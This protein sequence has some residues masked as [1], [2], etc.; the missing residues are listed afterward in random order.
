MDKRRR[1]CT[2]FLVGKKASVDGSTIIARIED[3][4]SKPNPQRFVVVTPDKQPKKFVSAEYQISISLPD[5]PLRYTSTPDADDTHGVWAGAGINSENVAMTSSETIT[6]NSKILALDPLVNGI[7]EADI[8][9]LVLPYIYSAKE[10]VERL[11]SLLETYGTYES[12]GIS[13]SDKEEVWYMETIGGHHWVAQRIPDEAYVIAPNRFNIT[14][15][16]FQSNNTLASNGL[17]Q[18]INT[19]HLNPDTDTIN[20]RHIF[21]SHTEKDMVYNNPRAWY[22]QRY[23][24]PEVKQE[25]TSQDLPFLCYANRKISIEDIDY[26]LSSHFQNTLFDPYGTGTELEKKQFRAIGLNRNLETHILQIRSD[27]PKEISGIHWLA[28]GPNT[29]TWFVPFYSNVNSTPDSY[30]TTP[31]TYDPTSLFWMIRHIAVLGDSDYSLYS[32]LVQSYQKR[33]LTN[34]YHQQEVADDYMLT[35]LDSQVTDYLET[36]NQQLATSSLN[37]VISLLGDMVNLGADN[38]LLNFPVGD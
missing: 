13:F 9:S 4:G 2:T 35:H 31:T 33:A 21:G 11:G 5:L 23:F 32:G 30:A 24:N 6:N 16:D 10:G 34:F 14:D 37:F 38:M 29:F 22:V 3:G 15:F 26:V 19:H 28:F 27:V 8:L 25:P 12:N 17:E 1:S 7:G 18:L 20:L 36:V